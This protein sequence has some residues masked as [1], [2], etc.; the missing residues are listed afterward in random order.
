M[1]CD[2]WQERWKS[3][4]ILVLRF[5]SYMQLCPALRGATVHGFRRCYSYK[6]F[7]IC[8]YAYNSIWLYREFLAIEP[9][10]VQHADPQ[11]DKDDG[12]NLSE[13][14]LGSAQCSSVDTGLALSR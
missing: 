1:I 12:L 8:R 13:R 7:L 10:R 5:P 14:D 9:D 3:Y 4:E 6:Q 2:T 11:M